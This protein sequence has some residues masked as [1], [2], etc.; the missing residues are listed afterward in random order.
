MQKAIG[1]ALGLIALVTSVLGAGAA[2]QHH[3]DVDAA[4]DAQITALE[5]K[6]E[7]R[8]AQILQL[9]KALVSEFPNYTLTLDWVGL[10]TA[11]E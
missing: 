7:R 8:D 1:V 4:R 5:H 9:Q 10:T 6:L 2:W 11:K 3:T